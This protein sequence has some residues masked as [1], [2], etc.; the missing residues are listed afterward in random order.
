MVLLPPSSIC[1]QLNSFHLPTLRK[2]R[3]EDLE[4]RRELPS[5]AGALHCRGGSLP[6]SGASRGR[7]AREGCCPFGQ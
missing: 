1:I 3:A 5:P 7:T 2:G 6:W 4:D